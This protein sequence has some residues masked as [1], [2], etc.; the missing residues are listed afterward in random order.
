MELLDDFKLVAAIVA[1]GAAFGCVSVSLPPE[2]V[3]NPLVKVRSL[4]ESDPLPDEASPTACSTSARSDVS[5]ALDFS[6]CPCSVLMTKD[7]PWG[8]VAEVANVP[9]R[10]IVSRQFGA[11]ALGIFR[12]PGSSDCPEVTLK[13]TSMRTILKQTGSGRVK[14]R[15]EFRVNVDGRNVQPALFECGCSGLTEG[16]WDGV[17]VPLP[18]YQSVR[19]AAESLRADLLRHLHVFDKVAEASVKGHSVRG[20]SLLSFEMKPTSDDGIFCGNCRMACND[21]DSTRAANWLRAKI[22]DRS[23]EQLGVPLERVR[24][25]Y[26]ENNFDAGS[27]E[28]RVSFK[29]FAR[30]PWFLDYDQY[31]HTG[32]CAVDL[33]L[34]NLTAQQGA[35][36]MKE[37]VMQEMNR[38]GVVVVDGKKTDG[39][40]VRF[41]KFETDERYNVIRCTFKL[42]K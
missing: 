6:D 26:M 42:V 11:V 27:G 14:S 41:D 4:A 38:R 17:C 30:V 36:K 15:V 5:A 13:V 25:I 31:S 40:G 34:A 20:P 35:E 3:P 18:V 39:A 29:A 28:W 33:E 2:Y 23:R 1:T 10:D 8:T 32:I 19:Q 22:D 21:W 37:Y 9:L 7:T 24:V 16:P 12:A